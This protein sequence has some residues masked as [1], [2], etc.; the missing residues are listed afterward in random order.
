MN[1]PDAGI[2]L[3]FAN[4]GIEVT[5]NVVCGGALGII[6]VGY[7]CSIINNTIAG[8]TYASV[9]CCTGP[10]EL[11]NCILWSPSAEHELLSTYGATTSVYYCDVREGQGS[12]F[13]DSTSTIVWG[14]GNISDDPDFSTGPLSD[15]QLNPATSPCIDAGDPDPV[16]YDAEDPYNPGY[17]LWPSLGTILND[18]GAYGGFGVWNWLGISEESIL[19]VGDARLQAIPNPC[20]SISILVYELTAPSSIELRVFDFSGR[21][22][23]TLVEDSVSEGVYTAVF[24]GSDLPSGVYLCR[25]Q[26]G[27]SS[28][29]TQ[30]VL[31]R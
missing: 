22:V 12:C 23:R 30:V 1:G 15:F 31:I 14:E 16:Y 28:A 10:S 27:A 11:R 26:A 9:E 20:A 7:G 6:C 4:P 2:H 29:T 13:S 5:N 18:M 3:Y 8:T 19:P 24:D 25:L 21:A 17:A